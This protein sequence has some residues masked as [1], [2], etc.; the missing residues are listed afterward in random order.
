[1]LGD[2]GLEVVSGGSKDVQGQPM[3]FVF[4][5]IPGPNSSGVASLQLQRNLD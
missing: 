5:V 1:V 4:F 2:A 3:N